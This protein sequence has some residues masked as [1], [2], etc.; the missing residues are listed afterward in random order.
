MLL[1]TLAAALPIVLL[2]GLLATGRVSA[3]LSALIGLLAAILLAIFVFVPREVAESGSGGLTGWAG[4]VL[5]AAGNGAASRGPDSGRA[6]RVC[7]IVPTFHPPSSINS[8]RR[9]SVLKPGRAVRVPDLQRSAGG[10]VRSRV[11]G[12]AYSSDPCTQRN[13]WMSIMSRGRRSRRS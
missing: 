1:S 10:L 5:A 4:A 2:L 8:Y 3:H 12:Q 11:C 7:V 13:D 9:L 6:A